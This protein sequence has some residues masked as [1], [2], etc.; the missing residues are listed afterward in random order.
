MKE[1]FDLLKIY[2]SKLTR[3]QLLTFKGQIKKGDYIG[4]K[5]GLFKIM[6]ERE[7]AK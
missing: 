2:K 6:K 1:C 5:K 7:Y 3:Q 4:F